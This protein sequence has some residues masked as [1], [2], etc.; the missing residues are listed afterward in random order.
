MSMTT[1]Y[2]DKHEW[3]AGMDKPCPDCAEVSKLRA[4]VE[5][6]TSIGLQDVIR[7]ENLQGQVRVLDLQVHELRTALEMAHEGYCAHNCQASAHPDGVHESGC[8][9][10]AQVL[11][12]SVKQECECGLPITEAVHVCRTPH[13]FPEKQIQVA[14]EI[15]IMTVEKWKNLFLFGKKADDRPSVCVHCDIVVPMNVPCPKCGRGGEKR[16]GAPTK[17]PRCGVM[18]AHHSGMCDECYEKMVREGGA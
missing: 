17:C 2:C 15:G 8:Q 12:V 13:R 6:L 18:P 9:D 16:E 5:R 3:P 14:G 1:P 10:I 11:R 7:N 4:E